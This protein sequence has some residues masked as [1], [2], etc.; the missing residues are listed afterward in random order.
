MT[1]DSDDY[2]MQMKVFIAAHFA[3]VASAQGTMLKMLFDKGVLSREEYF[4]QVMS[5]IGDVDNAEGM[6]YISEYLKTLKE[7]T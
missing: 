2:D 1:T 7:L 3:A 4:S 5:S 6:R